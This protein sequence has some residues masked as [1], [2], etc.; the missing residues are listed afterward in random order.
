MRTMK[1]IVKKM[2]KMILMTSLMMMFLMRAMK[3]LMGTSQIKKMNLALLKGKIKK[4]IAILLIVTM[5]L[6][7]TGVV[8]KVPQSQW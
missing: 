4:E 6:K 3:Q 5:M 2:T 8:M 1:V 7:I